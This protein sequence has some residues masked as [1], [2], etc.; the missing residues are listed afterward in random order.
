MWFMRMRPTGRKADPA[1][2]FKRR[3]AGWFAI[4]VELTDGRGQEFSPPPGRLFA[5]APD[6]SFADLA[7]AIDHGFARW[8]LGHLH[9]FQLSDGTRVGLVHEDADD[10]LVDDRRFKLSRLSPG[11]QFVYVFD[12]GDDWTHRCTVSKGLIDPLERLGMV[13]SRPTAFFG[14]GQIPDQYGRTSG[15]DVGS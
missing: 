8:D 11:D 1:R 15:E 4:K 2:S 12:F 7:N 6:H 10:D 5:A 3:N 13:P 9:E 14:W